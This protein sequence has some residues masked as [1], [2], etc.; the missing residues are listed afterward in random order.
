MS[1]KKKRDRQPKRRTRNGSRGGTRTG[2]GWRPGTGKLSDALVEVALPILSRPDMPEDP[3]AFRTVLLMVG[4]AWNSVRAADPAE[5]RQ[6]LRALAEGL[7]SGFDFPPAE[8][9][10]MVHLLAG[11]ARELYP[12]DRRWVVDV[13]VEE[14]EDELRIRALS[15]IVEP[16]AP[17]AAGDQERPGPE[18]GLLS[19]AWSWL[20][21]APARSGTAAARGGTSKGRLRSGYSDHLTP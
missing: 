19:R 17:P 1:R 11:R 21:S 2:G 20:S 7:T 15:V 8:A 3:D 10:E 14:R 9:A 12:D 6:M 4:V 16:P 13:Q 5:E 18:R